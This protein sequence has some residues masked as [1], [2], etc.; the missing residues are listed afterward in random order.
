MILMTTGIFQDT[1]SVIHVHEDSPSHNLAVLHC[2]EAR[3]HSVEASHAACRDGY[4]TRVLAIQAY[5]DAMPD[6]SG[7]ENIRDFIACTAHGMI[8]DVIDATEGTKLLYAA[9]VALG[10]LQNQPKTPPPPPHRQ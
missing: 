5:R 3:R 6:L 7:Y 2:C 8:I 10:A 1:P 9:Q 4:D